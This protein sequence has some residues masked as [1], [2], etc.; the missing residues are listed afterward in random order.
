MLKRILLPTLLV[1]SNIHSAQKVFTRLLPHV[2]IGIPFAVGLGLNMQK[3]LLNQPRYSYVGV[4][5]ISPSNIPGLKPLEPSPAHIET[6]TDIKTRI[7]AE[8]IGDIPQEIETIIEYFT[9]QEAATKPLAEYDAILLDGEPGTGKNF[10]VKTLTEQLNIP[11]LST[12]GPRFMSKYL[13]RTNENIKDFFAPA[14]QAERPLFI[15]ID[16]ADILLMDEKYVTSFMVDES[17]AAPEHC[18]AREFLC[19]TI[20]EVS[21]KPNVF[22]FLTALREKD[23]TPEVKSTL[24][25]KKITLKKFQKKE[26]F[27]AFFKKSLRTCGFTDESEIEKLAPAIAYKLK[28]WGTWGSIQMSARPLSY[29]VP[30]ALARRHTDIH[31]SKNNPQDFMFYVS[32]IIKEMYVSKNDMSR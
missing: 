26:D 15:F 10:L 8:F 18:R 9:Q 20:H 28:G 5:P 17:P 27:I 32:K 14:Q 11:C 29:I 1:V 24:A 3:Y 25:F 30:D 23:I 13:G 22:V 2:K 19:K 4:S 7:S 12:D 21:Q 16:Y 31:L 6:K